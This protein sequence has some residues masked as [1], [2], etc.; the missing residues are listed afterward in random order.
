MVGL[1]LVAIGLCLFVICLGL[2]KKGGPSHRRR[3]HHRG[4][5]RRCWSGCWR[6]RTSCA[7]ARGSQ[8]ACP[9][10]PIQG[11]LQRSFGLFVTHANVG[12]CAARAAPSH[13]SGSLRCPCQGGQ[14]ATVPRRR[15][16]D[17]GT[18]CLAALV[19]PRSSNASA[20]KTAHQLLHREG[21]PSANN[22]SLLGPRP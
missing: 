16:N 9:A 6:G 15:R 19:S 21:E 5:H 14:S 13:Q 3:C 8:S 4:C 2:R 17:A 22:A 7:L 1:C 11:V 10:V 18:E 12:G 20:R